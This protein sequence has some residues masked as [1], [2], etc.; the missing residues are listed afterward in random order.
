MSAAPRER[1][2]RVV[3]P[4]TTWEDLERE[5]RRQEPTPTCGIPWPVCPGPTCQG[6]PLTMS[7]GECWCSLCKVRWRKAER[8]PCPDA[9]AVTIEDRDGIRAHVCSAHAA[10]AT[11]RCPGPFTVVN[12]TGGGAA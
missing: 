11:L 4:G 7:G 9:P 1:I 10:C 5:W 3:S 8:M 2:L 6:Q 12:S